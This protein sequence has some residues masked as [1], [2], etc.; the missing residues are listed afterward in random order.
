MK[1]NKVHCLE[2]INKG[3]YSK[4]DCCEMSFHFNLI[5]ADRFVLGVSSPSTKPQHKEEE[6]T[7]LNCG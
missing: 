5:E 7:S 2:N 6:A 4:L 1:G 3:H